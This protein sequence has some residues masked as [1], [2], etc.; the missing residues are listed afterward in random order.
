[1]RCLVLVFK[2]RDDQNPCITGDCPHER[3]QECQEWL[4]ETAPWRT[5]DTMTDSGSGS[6]YVIKNI[7]VDMAKEEWILTVERM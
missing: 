1:M 2:I 4:I 6:V 5:E 7:S 3:Q